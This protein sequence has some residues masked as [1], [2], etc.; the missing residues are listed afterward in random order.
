MPHVYT[1]SATLPCLPTPS[2]WP[3]GSSR[4]VPVCICLA[5]ANCLINS[6]VEKGGGKGRKKTHHPE[7]GD[8]FHAGV[9]KAALCPVASAD[10]CPHP[11]W[12]PQNKAPQAGPAGLT[13]TTHPPADGRPGL[14]R[15]ALRHFACACVLR[16]QT[17]LPGSPLSWLP[18]V[19]SG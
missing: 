5:P 15:S 13:P 6:C 16:C 9:S 3:L 19:D 4:A 14:L 7:E 10:P 1:K 12:Q 2:A 11:I 18:H 8:I 17:E